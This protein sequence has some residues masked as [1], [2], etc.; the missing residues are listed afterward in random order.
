[1]LKADQAD[2]SPSIPENQ[3]SAETMGNGEE[4]RKLIRDYNSCI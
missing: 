1:M 3:T 2:L 4:R